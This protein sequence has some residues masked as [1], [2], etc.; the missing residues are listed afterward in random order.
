MERTIPANWEDRAPCP[1]CASPYI[2]YV[3]DVITNRTRR[4]LPLWFCMDCRSFFNPSGYREDS[5]QKRFDFDYLLQHRPVIETHSHTLAHEIVIRT[6]GS[7]TVL[8]IGCGAGFFLNAAQCNGLLPIGYDVN[9]F[10]TQFARTSLGV[11]AR[12]GLWEPSLCSGFDLIVAIGVMEHVPDPRLLFRLMRDGLGKDGCIYLNVPFLDREHWRF[13]HDVSPSVPLSPFYDNDV[14]IT[15]FSRQGLV[16]LGTDFG[17]RSAEYFVAPDRVTN[18][19]GGSYP[20]VL[21]RF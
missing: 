7:K 3:R 5:Q 11:D 16:K 15:H 9:P 12:D 1:A 6:P 21:F 17:A 8:E 19:S 4:V 13:L 2:A 10:A 20:G 18:S 14:H